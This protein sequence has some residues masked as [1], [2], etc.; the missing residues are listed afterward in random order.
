M[1]FVLTLIAWV[2]SALLLAMSPV[3]SVGEVSVA[4]IVYWLA[5]VF[6]ASVLAW[7]VARTDGMT[8][9]FWA[10][11]GAAL[12][13]RL[14]G[15]I[16]PAGLFGSSSF[17]DLAYGTSYVLFS[18]ALLLLVA[19]AARSITLLAALDTLGVML[20]TG[21]ISWHFALAPVVSGMDWGTG[22]KSLLLA[23]SGPVF[24]VGLLCLALVVAYSNRSL[25]PRAFSLAGAFGAFLAADG[26]YLGLRLD[27][28]GG[29]PELFWALG[30]SLI[31]LAALTT[32]E[33]AGPVTGSVKQL[34]VSPRVVAIFWFSPLSPAVQLA[35]LLAWGTIRP[36][37]PSYILWGGAVLALYLALRIS[38]GTYTSRR[39]RGEAEQLAKVSERDRI[40]EDLHDTLKQCVHSV[41]MM[42]AAYQKTR[43]KDPDKAEIILERARRTSEEASYRVSGPVRELQIGGKTS[44][45][46]VRSL[47][48]QLVRDIR[49]SFNIEVE[50]DLQAPLKGLS[51]ERLAATYRITSEAL[52]NAARHS[53]AAKIKIKT[54]NI[55]S[56]FLVKVRDDG[57]GF[58][59]DQQ[60]A[61]M[62][63]SLMRRRAEETGGELDVI[64]N[65]DRGTTIQIRFND[66]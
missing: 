8:R 34:I 20:F 42:L 5:A 24:D 36:P 48:D 38:L 17:D 1:C 60:A 61:G 66:E 15:N 32:D 50:Q 16:G 40:S 23:R 58:D 43:D 52:W 26:L 30:I 31:G 4:L 46:D 11:V 9:V 39:L 25:A 7:A 19:R 2:V 3:S 62:G 28:A 35:F 54:H 37:L 45:L 21:L 6:A 51:P 44:T 55:G 49:R 56:V 10:I 22:L 13:F 63:L 53:G 27:Q 47:L 33:N 41:P 12:L 29:W 57:C 64:S 14:V 59:T 18:V 65:P